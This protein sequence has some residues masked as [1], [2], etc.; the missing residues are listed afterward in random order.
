[1]IL[2]KTGEKEVSL[3]LFGELSGDLRTTI[4][5]A[6]EEMVAEVFQKLLNNGEKETVAQGEYSL[7][8][9]EGI[10]SGCRF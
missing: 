1:M 3:R 6:L 4:A 8:K 2:R 10:A 7:E 5:V 9:G